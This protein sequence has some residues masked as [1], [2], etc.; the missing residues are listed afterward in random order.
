[1]KRILTN[2]EDCRQFTDLPS[3]CSQLQDRP[4]KRLKANGSLLLHHHQLSDE[5]KSFDR[6]VWWKEEKKTNFSLKYIYIF[7]SFLSTSINISY[8]HVENFSCGKLNILNDRLFFILFLYIFANK[9]ADF[10]SK[11]KVFDTQF[12]FTGD[13][14]VSTSHCI[15]A[16]AVF[17]LYFA[18]LESFMFALSLNKHSSDF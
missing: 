10:D 8:L 5:P 6:V 12:L 3:V 14:N 11:S 9:T 17:I 1:M 15:R 2:Q 16:T 4:F 7:L 18:S 13:Q